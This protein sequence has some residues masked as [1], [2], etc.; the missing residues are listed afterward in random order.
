MLQRVIY[1]II[2][3]TLLYIIQR[4][5]F[6]LLDIE[7]LMLI[8]SFGNQFVIKIFLWQSNFI[9]FCFQTRISVTTVKSFTQVMW[10]IQSKQNITTRKNQWDI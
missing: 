5:D 1:E 6:L 2:D 3:N 8:I 9:P 4:P 7:K 10:P